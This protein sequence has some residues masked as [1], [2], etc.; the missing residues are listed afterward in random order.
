MRHQSAP[1]SDFFLGNP[2]W[3]ED[4]F[5]GLPGS[6]SRKIAGA[7]KFRRV[8]KGAALFTRGERAEAVFTLVSG[9]ARLVVDTGSHRCLTRSI[10][11]GEV[12][13]LPEAVA[14]GSYETS[15]IAETVCVFEEVKASDFSFILH[16]SPQLC[17]RLVKVLGTNLDTGRRLLS[18]LTA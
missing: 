3:S 12:F 14:D 18:S 10:E 1:K 5:T 15:V 11:L 2:V 9:N 13:G 7:R 8:E 4:L 17:F 16:R 6:V